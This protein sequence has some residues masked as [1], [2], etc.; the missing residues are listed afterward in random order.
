MDCPR[1]AADGGATWKCYYDGTHADY[2]RIKIT[3]WTGAPLPA[4]S[5]LN[6]RIIVKNPVVSTGYLKDLWINIKSYEHDISTPSN[7]QYIIK[8]M[9]YVDYMETLHVK[10]PTALTHS[11][12]AFNAF[13]TNTVQDTDTE[14]TLQLLHGSAF[15][16]KDLG[17]IIVRYSP[18]FDLDNTNF[19]NVATDCTIA[20]ANCSNDTTNFPIAHFVFVRPTL[21]GADEGI[22]LATATQL[23]L[24]GFVNAVSVKAIEGFQTSFVS[25][26]RNT[27]D[28]VTHA[29]GSF[30]PLD[31]GTCSAPITFQPLGIGSVLKNRTESWVLRFGCPHKIPA[32]GQAEITFLN[33]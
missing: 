6:F 22:D 9:A 15:T 32:G 16:G 5:T 1:L 21:A 7:P 10:D 3:G 18:D 17:A 2:R 26:Y 27:L 12:A 33:S 13:N 28:V 8:D 25:I 23:T 30:T 20:G 11:G 24:K 14:L 19:L 31:P 4:G 29:T